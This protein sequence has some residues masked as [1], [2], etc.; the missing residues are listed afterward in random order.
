MHHARKTGGGWTTLFVG[1]GLL[2]GL[3]HYA[4][5]VE[6]RSVETPAPAPASMP[7]APSAE[8]APSGLPSGFLPPRG[9]PMPP[10]P[11]TLS[12][13]I[14]FQVNPVEACLNPWAS[15]R[16]KPKYVNQLV[17][18]FECHA[19]LE[20]DKKACAPLGM[21]RSGSIGHSAKSLCEERQSTDAAFKSFIDPRAG[22][23]SCVAFLASVDAPLDNVQAAKLCG[24]LISAQRKGSM[25]NACGEEALRDLKL[26]HPMFVQQVQYFCKRISNLIEGEDCSRYQKGGG[27]G[28]C[29]RNR[30]L[31]NAL[32]SRDPG[33]CGASAACRAVVSPSRNVCESRLSSELTGECKKLAASPPPQSSSP[34]GIPPEF[35]SPPPGFK[36]GKFPK[37]APPGMGGMPPGMPEG[38]DPAAAGLPPGM[39]DGGGAGSGAAP[40]SDGE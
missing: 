34:D 23:E 24:L 27:R 36:P 25:S 40:P 6:R 38:F 18:Y 39:S 15:A 2:A 14:G 3:Y 33:A 12:E 22:G 1:L 13:A 7:Q 29:E 10:K 21:F 11:P 32:K 35:G 5:K 30:T 20:K 28:E 37:G 16:L 26:P 17:D 9:S 19:V 4:N 31:L 8:T